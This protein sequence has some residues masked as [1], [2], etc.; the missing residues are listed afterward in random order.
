M[1][2]QSSSQSGPAPVAA[3]GY[4]SAD[5]IG[6]YRWVIC[7]LLFA[8]TTINYVDRSVLAVL[9]PTLKDKI[10]WNDTQYGDMNACFQGAYAL[11]LVLA[12]GLMDRFGT[13]I[14]YT[15]A[16]LGWSLAAIAH[17]FVHT[18]TGFGYARIALGLFE[19][20]NFPAAIKT[21]AEWFPK[22]E[23]SL[24]VGIF[25]CGANV[26]AIVAPLVVPPLMLHFGWQSAFVATGVAGLVWLF[27]WIPIYR[28]PEE[29]PQVGK[30]ELAYIFSD[31]IE[32]THKIPFL[33]LLPHRQTWAFSLAKMLTDPV[34]WFWLFWAAPY[35]S[36]TF[37]LDVKHVGLPLVTIY[38]MATFGSIGG[39]YLAT[40]FSKL[41]WSTNGCRKLAM[42]ICALSVLPVVL[43]PAVPNKWGVVLLI[44]VAAAAHQG[45]SANLFALS[46]DLFPRRAVG[47][48]VGIGGMLGAIAGIGFQS[49]AGRI[50]D[51]WGYL[52]LF[53]ICGSAYIL[54]MAI[55]QILSPQ[56]EMAKIDIDEPRGFEVTT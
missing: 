24:A 54:A 7:A 16:L 33:K 49:A 50:V 29:H 46:G 2:E 4:R 13:R 31:P 41:G 51:H 18:V 53:I 21:V 22:K 6:N 47:S 56:L 43:A 20:G 55:I 17:A 35:L 9:S 5:F 38:S 45:W 15:F 42:L 11:G 19:A 23:R 26:G 1:D 14:G 52:P 32:P 39:G 40:V 10:G 3:L 28:R 34:W 44:G 30:A 36:K 25:N 37:G 48:I 8:A 27:F 12:G